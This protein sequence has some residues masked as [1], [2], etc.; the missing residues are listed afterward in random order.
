MENQEPSKRGK[1][2]KLGKQYVAIG[3]VFLAVAVV[4]LF[5]M[6]TPGIWISFLVLGIVFTSGGATGAFEKKA[7]K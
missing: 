3:A 1:V 2:T 6:D 5:T 4:F 7:K